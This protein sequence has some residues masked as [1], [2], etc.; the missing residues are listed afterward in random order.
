MALLC[1][2]AVCVSSGQRY[3]VKSL[4]LA[5]KIYLLVYFTRPAHAVY[6]FERFFPVFIP[7]ARVGTV[8]LVS[9][10]RQCSSLTTP[11]Q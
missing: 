7:V 6:I 3:V 4:I 1:R 5:A 8:F 2:V 10:L 11:W 9:Q